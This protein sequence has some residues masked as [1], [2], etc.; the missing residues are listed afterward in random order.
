MDNYL[1]EGNK[2][3]EVT[4]LTKA[5]SNTTSLRTTVPA[6]IVKQFNLKEKD[7]LDW[8]LIVTEGEMRISIKPLLSLNIR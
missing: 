7:Q 4:T 2:M 8:S 5:A 6:S 3:G 1:G